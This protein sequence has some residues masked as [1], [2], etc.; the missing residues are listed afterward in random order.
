[1]GH[2]ILTPVAPL[3]FALAT[4]AAAGE[5]LLKFF[6]GAPLERRFKSD[7]TLVTEADLAA[8]RAITAALRQAF[9]QDGLISEEAGTLYRGEEAVWIVDPLDG[10]TNFQWGLPIWGV[11][12]ARWVQGSPSLGVLHFPLLGETY[13]ARRGSGVT[14][15]GKPLHRKTD[16]PLTF[17]ACCSRTHRR[18]RLALPHKTRILGAVSYNMAQVAAGN[19]ALNL[20][21]TPKLWDVAAGWLIVEESGGVMHIME[22][23]QPI[24]LQKGTDYGQMHFSTLAAGSPAVLKEGLAGIH[25]IPAEG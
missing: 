14:F 10:T 5:I 11:S 12:L 21:V 24:P 3:D 6:R 13:A 23:D 18:Y 19:A 4:A 20:E 9:P 2:D 8:N 17:F 15:N 22:G 1:M 7:H 25:P 16:L